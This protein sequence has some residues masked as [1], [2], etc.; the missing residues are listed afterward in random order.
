VFNPATK[1]T[2]SQVLPHMDCASLLALFPSGACSAT[3]S[4]RA[5]TTA[6]RK[7]VAS[8]RTPYYQCRYV[9]EL[10]KQPA[11]SDQRHRLDSTQSP[12]SFVLLPVNFLFSCEDFIR[13]G[14]LFLPL[15]RHLSSYSAGKSSKVFILHTGLY[16]VR[17]L[18]GAL[19]GFSGSAE[20]LAK[21]PNRRRTP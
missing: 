15:H 10:M 21:A 14:C 1:Y 3:Q 2:F 11:C 18:F 19:A 13:R 6:Q 8:Y 5:A 7:A 9:T 16:G 4:C 12:S 20:V 17:R